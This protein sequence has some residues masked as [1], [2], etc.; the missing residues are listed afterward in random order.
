MGNLIRKPVKKILRWI[1]K[2]PPYPD[3]WEKGEVNHGFGLYFFRKDIPKDFRYFFQGDLK[4]NV[5]SLD[6]LCT[7]LRDCEYISDRA[8]FRKSDYWQH[9]CEFERTRK[10]DCEDHALW[11]WR[12]LV[13]LGFEAE[14][15]IGKKHAWVQFTKDGKLYLLETI[16]KKTSMWFPV[17]EVKDQYIPHW[18]INGKFQRFS[19]AGL[20][21]YLKD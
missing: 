4:S 21:E 18:S 12:K 14:F 3:P 8:Q 20:L 10:G 16:T 11:A 13:E 1:F 15:V 6:E 17:D 2:V 7:W 9:P 19:Y 5:H